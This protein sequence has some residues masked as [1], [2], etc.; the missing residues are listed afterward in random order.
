MSATR[1]HWIW[2]AL[3]WIAAICTTGIALGV[4][5]FPLVGLLFNLDAT[6]GE[7]ALRG[8]RILGFYFGIWA[9]G[10]ALVVT[11]KREYEARRR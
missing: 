11:V 9:P 10:V 8:A 4:I 6:P 7:L 2:Y 1:R 3:G 5:V